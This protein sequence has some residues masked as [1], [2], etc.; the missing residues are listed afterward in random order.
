M[1]NDI[2]QI[3]KAVCA[4]IVFSLVYVL[5]FALIIKIFGISTSVVKPVNQVF[6]IIV[7][8]LGGLI[9]LRGERGVIKGAVYGLA[10]ALGTYLLYGLI[11]G[12]FSFSWLIIAEL[13][14][15]ALAGAV[16]GI[17]AVNVKG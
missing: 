8:A 9:F 6:K 17:I 14:L 12:G 7:I 1:H 2:A 15:G 3:F 11:G 10:A 16:S 13:A 5:A 4:A